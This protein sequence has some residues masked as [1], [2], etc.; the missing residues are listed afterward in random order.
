MSNS[1]DGWTKV[2]GN[3]NA[4]TWDPETEKE[5]SG[6]YIDKKENLGKN[7]SNLYILQQP[8]GS[9]VSVWG[10]SVLDNNF[11]RIQLQSE[12]RIVYLGRE[13]ND[14]TGRTFKNFDIFSRR[15]QAATAPTSTGSE[16]KVED[17]SP[18]DIPF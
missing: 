13:T 10:S 16:E 18:D 17:V 7:H 2:S 11:N 4:R 15:P 14:K 6:R 12:V 3:V 8:D 1:N 9:E 5:V